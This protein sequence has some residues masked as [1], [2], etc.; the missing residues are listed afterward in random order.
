[1]NSS[2]AVHI[3]LFDFKTVPMRTFHVTWMAFFM[4]FFGWFGIAPLMPLVRHD[5]GLTKTQIGN[6]IIA[7]V[8]I[9]I[10]VR[11]IIGWLCD[12]FGPRRVYTGLL[13][14]GSFPVM[15]IGLSHN[16][17]TFLLFRLAIG[18]IGAS[19]VITQ[20]H[21][22]VMFAPNCVGTASATT[23]GWGNLGGGVAQVV[24]P[25]FLAGLLGFGLNESVAWRLTM[26]IPGLVLLFM[27]L[28]YWR[29]TKDFPEGNMEELRAAGKITE[30]S[31]MKG[32]FWAAV[33]D[34]RVWALFIIYGACFGIELTITNIAALY[35][36]DQFHLSLTQAGLIAGLFGLMNIFARTL[37]GVLSDRCAIQG[38]LKGRVRLLGVTLF[39]GGLALMI[40]AKMTL[41]P[42]AIM[43]M[44]I[45]S[46]FGKM[47]N[48]VTYSVIPFIN[49]KA[50][51]AVTGIV[52]AGGN[53]GA[54]LF[55]FLFRADSFSYSTALLILGGVVTLSSL[56]SFLVKFSLEDEKEV[57]REFEIAQ[58]R[59][60]E[61]KT[62]QTG[63]LSVCFKDAE[64]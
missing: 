30:K 59:R 35:Y 40:F 45:F 3:N 64:S 27:G 31:K 49:K 48:G 62:A 58:T 21:T 24:M 61:L 17:E 29:F 15:A 51:G 39:W 19:F 2:K 10:L 47:A 46:L 13:I 14:L 38:G 42:L 55:G 50:L 33:K 1:M 7:S 20:Y 32:S 57:K 53:T 54:V 12:R 4:C 6:T 60:Q 25:L 41:L 18:A 52:G 8:M 28:I 16:Y 23:S 63:P 5:L 43:T 11:L 26:V 37:G 44:I 22:S 56:V 34:Y 9:T 36:T